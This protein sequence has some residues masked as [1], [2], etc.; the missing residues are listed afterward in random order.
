[1]KRLKKL[2]IWVLVL[3][4]ICS[5]IL[6]PVFTDDAAAETHIHSLNG[7][8]AYIIHLS[9]KQIELLDKH[10]GYGFWSITAYGTD[11]YLI[12]NEENRYCINDRNVVYNKDGSIDIYVAKDAPADAK[13]YPNWLPVGDESFNLYFRIYLPCEEI[14]ENTWVMPGIEK[15][16]ETRMIPTPLRK[17]TSG[18]RLPKLAMVPVR[19]IEKSVLPTPH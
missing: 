17:I 10:N 9:R 16:T 7:K 12:A 3:T 11:Q 14:L 2:T 13:K 18:A 1:M 15:F 6:V 5:V 19:G 4:M 8:N